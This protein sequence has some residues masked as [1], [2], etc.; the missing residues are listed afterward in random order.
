MEISCHIEGYLAEKC[1]ADKS[2]EIRRAFSLV[3]GFKKLVDSLHHFIFAAH[4]AFVYDSVGFFVFI[5]CHLLSNTHKDKPADTVLAACIASPDACS[6]IL[7]FIIVLGIVLI[8]ARRVLEL[9]S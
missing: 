4:F 6:L 8:F 2:A 1:T 9:F 3:E 7:E 5:Y